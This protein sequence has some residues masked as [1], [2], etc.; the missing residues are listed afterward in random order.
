M[1]FNPLTLAFDHTPPVSV[2][3][4]DRRSGMERC[5]VF[6]ARCP[7]ANTCQALPSGNLRLHQARVT[8][9]ATH[10][11]RHPTLRCTCLDARFRRLEGKHASEAPAV[12]VFLWKSNWLTNHMFLTPISCHW[13][14]VF[15]CCRVLLLLL[16]CFCFFFHTTKRQK[17]Y[18]FVRFAL[19]PLRYFEEFDNLPHFD[20][21]SCVC[22]LFS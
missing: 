3:S 1:L 11:K 21:G 14:D 16:F 7:V 19:P 20:N 8:M 5:K 17:K 4:H 13:V 12:I 15:W 6:P 22:T 9:A 10:L 2:L 18:Y